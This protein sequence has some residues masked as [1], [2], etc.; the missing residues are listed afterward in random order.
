MAEP[1]VYIGKGK[2]KKDGWLQCTI[3]QKGIQAL[4]DNLQEYSGTKFAKVN[5]NIYDK[6]D[7]FGK[8][9]AI[10]LDTW[11]PNGGASSEPV[12]VNANTGE[13]GDANLP[14]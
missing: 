7:Q 6:P 10:T 14:F 3:T 11:K 12:A 13:I 1:K 4:L 2:K 8:D 5:I 9:V